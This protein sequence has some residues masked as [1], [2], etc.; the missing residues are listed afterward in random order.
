MTR[1]SD[2]VAAPD[3]AAAVTAPTM[4]QR[5]WGWLRDYLYVARWMGMALVDRGRADQLLHPVA[6]RRSP[7]LLIPGVFESWRFLQ[8]V[9]QHLYRDGHPVHVVDGLGYNTGAISDM[10]VLVSDYLDR[11]A[12]DQV[13]VVAHSKGGLIAKQAMRDPRT[14]ARVRHLIAVNTPF[15]G[16]RYAAWFLLPS[17]RMFAPN[18]PIIRALGLELA[19]NHRISS[20]Y[21][22]FDPHIPET[23][24]LEGAEN[25][26]LPTIGH[27]RPLGAPST[28]RLISAILGR[29]P[30]D[31]GADGG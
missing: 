19:I 12:L 26:V 30:E 3:P 11:H 7:V 18:G 28:L 2:A 25:I 22:V 1:R 17:V 14:L 9:A 20:L 6:R 29:T 24:F 10:A 16:S 21:S 31:G 8:P 15:S 5:L 4:R 27:F 23:S 13:T